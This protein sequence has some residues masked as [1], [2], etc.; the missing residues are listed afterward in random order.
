VIVGGG[1]G[2]LNAAQALR[3][4]PVRVTLIDRQNS[5]VFRPMLYQVATGMLPASDIAAPLRSVL[6][7]SRNTEVVM[8]EVTGI[9]TQNQQVLMGDR[10][11]P[12]DYLIL[13][14]GV[15]DNYFG[16][17]DWK[18]LAP[19]LDSLLDA[20]RIRARI[21]GVF[22]EAERRAAE[23]T[24]DRE[25][26]KALLTFVLVGAGPTGIEMAGSIV[27]LTH[28]ALNGEF[29]HI[30]PRSAR[31]VVCEAGPRILAAFPEDLAARAR[32]RLEQLGV[33]VRT[34][35]P[36]QQVD[37]GGV[38]VDGERIA[39]RTVVW[40]AGVAASPAGKWL[41]AETDRAG[42]VK[43][44]PDLSVPGHPNVF[45]I[46]DTASLAAPV[47]TLIGRGTSQPRPIPGLAQPAIQGGRYVAALIERRLRSQD[48][49]PPFQYLDKGTMAIV[50]NHFAI[51]D[52]QVA[53]LSGWVAW[54]GWLAIHVLS[55]TGLRNRVLVMGQWA[56]AL[57]SRRRGVRTFVPEAQAEDELAPAAL[58]PPT[59][60]PLKVPVEA[61]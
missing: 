21:L 57:L 30:D 51:A 55:L 37:A 44:N 7:R 11:L 8:D 31:I 14:T 20:E 42:R 24:P 6:R 12:Y 48:P 9:D 26:L 4:A 58:D 59:S 33:E 49:P 54:W 45:V 40:A 32:R 18:S 53:H 25:E 52:L 61:G 34:G 19:G 28:A 29:R 38:I 36:V 56:I 23:E 60:N 39:S 50:G 2:G 22:E 17:N 13:A 35:K 3:H 10:S 47:R 15:R 16:H 5:Q 46:G 27:G 1:F 43:V 41:G